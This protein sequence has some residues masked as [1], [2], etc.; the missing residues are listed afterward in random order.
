MLVST[1]GTL[2]ANS[3]RPSRRHARAARP[4]RPMVMVAMVA[5]SST[6]PAAAP[7]PQPDAPPP[8]RTHSTGGFQN[9]DSGV[10][11][12]SRRLQQSRSAHQVLRDDRRVGL[13]AEA[14]L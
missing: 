10:G 12:L 9:D 7:W 4:P 3:A 11:F 8:R 13:D 14:G 2:S 5:A 1:I 6:A